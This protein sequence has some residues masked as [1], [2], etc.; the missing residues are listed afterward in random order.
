ME[1]NRSLRRMAITLTITLC[2]AALIGIAAEA[3]PKL[4][5]SSNSQSSQPSQPPQSGLLSSEFIYEE[6]PFPECHASTIVESRGTLIAAWF[7]GTREK[8]PDVGI[9]LSRLEG[10][11]WTTPVE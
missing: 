5:H 10:G 1:V 3:L 11:K 7:G 9:W 8:H 2:S 4:R 6:A